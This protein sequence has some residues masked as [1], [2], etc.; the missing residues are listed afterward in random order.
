ACGEQTSLNEMIAILNAI[1]ES[2]LIPVYGPERQGDV[3]HSLAGIDKI[4]N[5]LHY[6]PQVYFKEGL[7]KVYAWYKK[8]AK[9]E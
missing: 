4:Q 9:I 1:S 8:N 2:E 3:K 7:K 5:T 6:A